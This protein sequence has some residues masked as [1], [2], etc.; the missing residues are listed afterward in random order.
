MTNNRC[1]RFGIFLYSK[2]Y[3]RYGNIREARENRAQPRYCNRGR[4]Y[5]IP[6]Q[7]AGRCRAAVDSEVR[8]PVESILIRLRGQFKD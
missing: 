7:K 1:I 4:N 3:L 5:K 8:I 6:R 2:R